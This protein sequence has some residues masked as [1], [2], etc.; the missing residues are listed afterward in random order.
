MSNIE[1]IVNDLKELVGFNTISDRS[2]IK[3][4]DWAEDRFSKYG[5]V[6]KRIPNSEGTKQNLWARFGAEEPGGI[7]LSGHT[8][9]VPVEGQEWAS[10]PFEVIEKSGKLYGRGTADMKCFLAFCSAYASAF[11]EVRLNRPVHIALSYDEELGCTGAPSMIEQIANSGARPSLAWIGEPTNW[12]VVS[13][14]KGNVVTRVEVTGHEAHSSQTHLGLSAVESAMTL[15]TVLQRISKELET[16]A[17]PESPFEPPHT[18]L[19]VGMIN[20][21]TAS[22]ILAHKCSFLFDLRCVPGISPDDVLVPFYEAVIKLDAEMKSRFP[23]TGVKVERLCNAPPLAIDETGEGETFVR[24]ITGDNSSQ[25]VTY[26]AEAGQF[27][28]AGMSAVLCGPGSIDQAHRPN[29]FIETTQIG[30]GV[31]VFDALINRLTA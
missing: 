3:L 22:N 18:T 10:D 17:P 13:G 16:S 7:V 19:T 1:S 29:E 25:A 12:E 8:D 28:E 20:G 27:S 30:Q 31:R 21:G 14:H 2:N 15:L 4:I 5:A 24:Q 6:C 11:G 9:V 23:A 26:T